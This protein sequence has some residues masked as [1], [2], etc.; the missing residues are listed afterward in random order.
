MDSIIKVTR[1]EE[2]DEKKQRKKPGTRL[3]GNLDRRSAK[4]LASVDLV[5]LANPVPGFFFFRFL[6]LGFG[7]DRV[8][9]NYAVSLY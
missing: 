9:C 6:V 1:L 8:L 5:Y 4:Q 7:T 3:P 2:E